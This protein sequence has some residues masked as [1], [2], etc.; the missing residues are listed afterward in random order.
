MNTLK[1]EYLIVIKNNNFC[2]SPETFRNFLNAN[3]LVSIDGQLIKFNKIA[4]EYKL[5]TGEIKE[6][7]FF[8][9][10]FVYNPK[11]GIDENIDD[12]IKLLKIIRTT[13]HYLNIEFSVLWDD[14]SLYYSTKAY[15]L[16]HEIE[17]LMRKLITKFMLTNVGIAWADETSPPEIKFT[18]RGGKSGKSIKSKANLL[19]EKDFIDLADFLFEPYQNHDTIGI[20]KLLK[21]AQNINDLNL[22]ELKQFIPKSNWHRY[23]FGINYEDSQLQ[24]KWKD[25]YQ[26]RCQVAHNNQ[27]T[28][29][30]YEAILTLVNELRDK[31][32]EAVEQLDKIEI[33]E[34][35]KET[36][37][38]NVAINMNALFGEFI[39]TWS[40]FESELIKTFNKSQLNEEEKNEKRIYPPRITMQELM[41]IQLIDHDFFKL[42]TEINDFRNRSVHNAHLIDSLYSESDIRHKILQLQQLID[43]LRAIEQ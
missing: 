14:I 7:R 17:N 20:Y 32:I 1:V 29:E 21:S 27:V 2:S 6:H 24:K 25:L 3:D 28:K 22:D 33:S 35:E 12:Y 36:I 15:P 5:Q 13:V 19:Y 42:A 37:A 8:H 31:L 16:I 43:Q 34:E 11:N 10:I 39:K 23:F 40:M 18:N 9:L 41:K 30:D 26:L 38:E 4:V